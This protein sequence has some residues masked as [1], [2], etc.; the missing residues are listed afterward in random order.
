MMA[1]SKAPN[2]SLS[3]LKDSHVFFSKAHLKERKCVGYCCQTGIKLVVSQLLLYHT[4]GPCRH[5]KLP[6]YSS[7]ALAI[8]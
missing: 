6:V 1:S 4:F 3:S 2:M 5:A 8:L 7:F